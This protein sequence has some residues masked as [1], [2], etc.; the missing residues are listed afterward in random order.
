MASTGLTRT[1]FYRYFPDLEAV[2][3][4]WLEE[5]TVELR[6]T[7]DSW[8]QDPATGIEVGI[9]FVSLYKSY[10]RLLLAVDQAGG[11]GTD[12]GEAWHALTSDFT[13]RYSEFIVELCRRGNST[14]S[15]PVETARALVG[16]TGRYLLDAYGRGPSVPVA[17]AAATL[18]EIWQRTLFCTGLAMPSGAEVAS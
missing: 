13:T 17:V 15:Y 3:L 8:L 10:G 18:A 9:A 2:L 7:A 5:F 12:V 4:R 1:S 14:V 16:M 6:R 11:T